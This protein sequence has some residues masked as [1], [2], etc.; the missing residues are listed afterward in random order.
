[1]KQY[2]ITL[3]AADRLKEVSG[4]RKI[5]GMFKE[6][7]PIM[8]LKNKNNKSRKI[9]LLNFIIKQREFKSLLSRQEDGI[10]EIAYLTGEEIDSLMQR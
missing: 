4:F 9:L 3:N 6:N 8:T 10:E 5:I 1:M 7:D 2:L